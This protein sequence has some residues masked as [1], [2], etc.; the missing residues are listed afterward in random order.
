M[1]REKL[2]LTCINNNISMKNVNFNIFWG[3][4]TFLDWT[5]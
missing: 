2:C 5:Y 1:F 4:E 3:C